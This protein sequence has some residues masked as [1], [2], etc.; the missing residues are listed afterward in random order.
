MGVIRLAGKS[1]CGCEGQFCVFDHSVP[2][3][4]FRYLGGRQFSGHTHSALKPFDRVGFTSKH[5]QHAAKG[6]IYCLQTR[7]EW[8]EARRAFKQWNCVF[9]SPPTT[10]TI[11]R[12]EEMSSSSGSA[13]VDAEQLLEREDPLVLAVRRI[14]RRNRAANTSGEFGASLCALLS[15]VLARLW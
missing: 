10:I 13:R 12:F 7:R 8:V 1:V 3:F 5:Y 6:E 9:G 11:G 14:N 15:R 2:W 4:A